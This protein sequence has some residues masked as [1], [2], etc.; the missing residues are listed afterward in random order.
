MNLRAI[1]IDDIESSRDTLFFLIQKYCKNIDVIA[2]AATVK[3]SVSLIKEHQPDLVFLD[4][5]MPEENGFA[6]FDYFPSPDFNVIFTT[7][8]DEYAIRAFKISA[9]DYL[10]KPI[11]LEELKTAVKKVVDIRDQMFFQQRYQ[12]LKEN[13]NSLMNKI[14]LPTDKGYIFAEIEKIVRCEAV[15]NYTNFIFED[16]QK[17]MVSKTLK[18]FED[19]LSDFNFFRISRSNLVNMNFVVQFG[20]NKKSIQLSDDSILTISERR[21]KEFF[22]DFYYSM[23]KTN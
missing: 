19:I 4:I 16:G 12:T 17:I 5:E 8:Y 1:I 23:K 21:R 14:I 22:E 6:L 2:Q 7:A 15:S 10:L 13:V 3:S 9:V 20:L 11:N 18:T